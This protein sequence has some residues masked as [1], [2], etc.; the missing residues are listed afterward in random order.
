MAKQRRDWRRG[1][2]S[3]PIV[4]DQY[5][6]FT[7]DTTSSDSFCYSELLA[8][9]LGEQVVYNTAIRVLFGTATPYRAGDSVIT[10]LVDLHVRS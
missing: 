3:T 2:F 1:Q 5:R 10:K 9:L 4:T 8:Q 7:D 6:R